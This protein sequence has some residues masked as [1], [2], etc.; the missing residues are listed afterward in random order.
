MGLIPRDNW[1]AM[2]PFFNNLFPS[3]DR[4]SDNDFLV[5][6]WILPSRTNITILLPIYQA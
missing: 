4:N 6:G 1:F 2:E 5:Q 3:N